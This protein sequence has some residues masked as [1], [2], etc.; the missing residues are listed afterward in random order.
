MQDRRKLCVVT[1]A[2]KG[3]GYETALTLGLAGWEVVL[4][5]RSFARGNQAVMSLNS[6]FR[7]LDPGSGRQG[8]AVFMELDLSSL[9]SIKAFI[10]GFKKRYQGCD[11]LI[12]NAGV[13]G[14]PYTLTAEGFEL[15]FGVNYLGHAALFAQLLPF[16]RK[17]TDARVV[18]V[19]S[20]AHE[21][22]T[23]Q[24]GEFL[25][26]ARRSQDTYK[27]W[28]AYCQSKLLQVFFTREAQEVLGSS[29]LRFYATH[30]GV[31]PTDLLLSP[32]P[33]F[34]RLAL[35]PLGIFLSKVGLLTTPKEGS[36]TSTYLVL[37][38]PAPPAGTYW[39]AKKER[40]PHSLVE[41]SS[42]RKEVWQST[43]ELLA[44]FGIQM[45]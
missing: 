17:S 42:L 29:T 44:N 12:C 25:Q 6:I 11:A 26:L 30:P 41:N 1:G 5:C 36:D 19:S 20:R 16:L 43:W 38:N 21:R 18:Q 15:Q 24:P 7:Q 13:M 33:P 10:E 22:A 34:L 28:P 9:A 35:Q 40:A 32:L 4:A 8:L 45:A 39:A 37:T 23:L 14:G 27:A 31:I 3:I 2:N